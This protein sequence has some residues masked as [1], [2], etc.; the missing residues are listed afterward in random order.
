[1]VQS[2]VAAWATQ[3]FLHVFITAIGLATAYY[4]IPKVINRPVHSYHLASTGFWAFI[5]FSGLTGAVRLS[6][7]PLPVWLVTLSIAATIL[8]IVQIA[9]V[10]ANLLLTMD[11]Q[12]HMAY[13]SPTIRFTV[14][15]ALSFTIASVVGLLASLRSFDRLLHF[16]FSS[17]PR[18]TCCFTRSSAW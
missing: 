18:R 16:T 11:G 10:S 3:N 5:L 6:G 9:T 7:G 2:L 17:P 13:H 12:Y 15:G 4:L 14:F 1:M 8:L